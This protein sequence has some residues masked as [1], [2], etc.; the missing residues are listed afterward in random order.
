MPAFAAQ[1][2]MP[3]WIDLVTSEARK[4]SYFYSKLLG[5]DIDAGDYRV[6]RL[7]G[8][9]VAGMVS[10]EAMGDAWV[11]YFFS[12]DISADAEKVAEL[13]GRVV[14]EPTEV[15]LGTM[16][17]C[18]DVAGGWFGLFQPAGEDAF[19]AAGEPGTPVWHE[20]TSTSDVAAVIDFYGDLFGWEIV[21]NN[22]YYLVMAD[23]AAFAGIWDAQDQIPADVPSFW[24]TYLGVANIAEARSRISEFGGEVLRGPENSPFGLLLTAVDSTGAV[25]TLCEVDEPVDEDALSEADSI[26]D[27]M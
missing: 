1:P 12:A 5:W 26:L 14:A 15:S 24:Q 4:S 10:A 25:V 11:T 8:L 19:V 9:P 16:A 2:G 27:F 21:E 20:Y 13:G 23:G 22:G 18:A 7:Q 17:L 3:Y 6:A